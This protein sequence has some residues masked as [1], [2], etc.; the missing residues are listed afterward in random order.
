MGE[1]VASSVN[2]YGAPQQK[3][4]SLSQTRDLISQKE[5]DR[6]TVY[7]SKGKPG[8][9]SSACSYIGQWHGNKK[10]G[11]GTQTWASGDK[12]AGEWHDGKPSGFGTF[13]KKSKKGLLKQY[14]GQWAGGKQAGRGVYYYEDGGVFDGQWRGGLRHGVGVMSFEDGAVYE[15][16][17]FNDK[18]HG[19][20]ILDLLNGDH[21]EG[22]YI[23]D[24]R[25]GEGVHFFFS[26]EKKTHHKRMDGEWVD[27]VCKCSIYSEMEPDP[28]VP[29]SEVPEPLPKLCLL[30]PDSVLA[31]ELRRIRAARAHH[32]AAR[33][34]VDEHFTQEELLTL[35][36]AFNRVDPAGTGSIGVQQLR[37][38]FSHI[39]IDPADDELDSLIGSL[40]VEPPSES[41][42]FSFAE[43]AQACDFLSPVE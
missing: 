22:H 5:G 3:K 16:D 36:T 40:R 10:H 39:G 24:K 20:G 38:A 30:K 1:S 26:Q 32:R 18:R 35:R 43:F 15:G 41:M 8:A 11:K 31:T 7:W 4:L 6:R 13:W 27:D 21:F 42:M 2:A 25:E 9:Y 33:V 37:E 17:W 23:E 29:A 12:Y 28:N 34:T 19:F 14:A